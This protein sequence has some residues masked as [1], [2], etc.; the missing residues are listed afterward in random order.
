MKKL[1]NELT[2]VSVTTVTFS[3]FGKSRQICSIM[4]Q[5]VPDDLPITDS[6]V[7][8][9]RNGDR[10][11]YLSRDIELAITKAGGNISKFCGLD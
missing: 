11:A 9:F 5:F 10:K 4:H 1:L 2:E 8:N 7:A 6:D 3:G